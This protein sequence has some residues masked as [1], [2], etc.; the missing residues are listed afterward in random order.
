VIMT[1]IVIALARKLKHF[2]SKYLIPLSYAAIMGGTCT[3][4]GTSTNIL[5]DGI[6][7]QYGEPAFGIFQITPAG[8]CFA[9]AGLAYL[10]RAGRFLLPERA[11]PTPDDAPAEAKRFTA[12]ATIPAGSPLIGRT[13][14]ELQLTYSAD[15]EIMD[16]VRKGD[17]SGYCIAAGASTQLLDTGPV[18][19]TQTL[20]PLT[21]GRRR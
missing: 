3:L 2:P 12:E 11:L 7:R 5:V 8:L 15:Y 19:Q 9:A 1:P 20:P 18:S 13:L 21:L 16:L 14:K 10:A 4:I 17:T 6:A